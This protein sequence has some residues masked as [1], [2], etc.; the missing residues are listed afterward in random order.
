MNLNLDSHT[1][2]L[3]CSACGQ[4]LQKTI[5][6]LKAHRQFDCTCG[7]PIT[8]DLTQFEQTERTLQ[9]SLDGLSAA[10]GKR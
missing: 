5:G 7:K 3:P 8:V 6:W 2:E 10:F 4:K 1:I 9:K